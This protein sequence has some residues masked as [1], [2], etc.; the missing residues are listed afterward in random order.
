MTL[1]WLGIVVIGILLLNGYRGYKRG[2]VREVVSFFFVFLALAAAWAINPYVNDFF[3]ETTPV[4]EKIQESCQEFVSA[5]E[6][7]LQADSGENKKEEQKNFIDGLELPELLQQS[8][9]AN[10][11]EDVYNYLAV[12]TFGNYV[13]SYLARI[14]VNGTVVSGILF[15]GFR[16]NQSGNVPSGSYCGASFDQRSE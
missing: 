10:N 6:E 4:Y 3:M 7:E 8:L 2:F 12:D 5:K 16:Y 9:N 14:I 13:S 15:A 11:T 1:T